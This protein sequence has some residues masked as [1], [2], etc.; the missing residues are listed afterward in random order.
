[1]RDYKL[2]LRVILEAINRIENSME[3]I[4]KE[5]FEKDVDIQDV[6]L[7]RLEIIGE[8]ASNIPSVIKNKYLN[9]EW[10]KI[11][12]FRIVVAHTYFKVDMDIVWDIVKNELPKLKKELEGI[13]IK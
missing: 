5:F 13:E 8:A 6:V 4:A 7:R 10:K 1:M 11:M 3:G 9:V 2:Y 12:G